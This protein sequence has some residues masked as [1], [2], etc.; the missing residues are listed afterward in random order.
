[1]TFLF[2]VG[3]SEDDR[4]RGEFGIGHYF[5]LHLPVLGEQKVDKWCPSRAQD[6]TEK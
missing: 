3:A 5:Q 4:K 6:E 2:S 1:M